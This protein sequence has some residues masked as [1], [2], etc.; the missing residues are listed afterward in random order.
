MSVVVADA[1]V[2]AKWF[3]TEPGSTTATLLLHGQEDLAGPDLL[4]VECAA[5]I[6]RRFRTGGLDQSQMQRLLGEAHAVFRMRSIT[7]HDNL[8]LLPRAEEI[9]LALQHPLQDCLYIACAQA[10]GGEL[11]TADSTLLACAAPRFPFVK[12]L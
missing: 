4:A 5:A 9:A 10:V 6:V 7:L 12:P 1:S 11:I 3:L 2:A 8:S